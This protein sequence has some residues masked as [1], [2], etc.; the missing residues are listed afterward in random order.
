MQWTAPWP[1]GSSSWGTARG[2]PG[3]LPVAV[4]V[5]APAAPARP[6]WAVPVGLAEE[7]AAVLAA[8]RAQVAVLAGLAVVAAAVGLEE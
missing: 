6:V 8:A 7:G 1:S 2:S 5:V 3:A 4:V